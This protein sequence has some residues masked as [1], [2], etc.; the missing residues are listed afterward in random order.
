MGSIPLP[1]RYDA[2][3]YA[4]DA[5]AVLDALAERGRT[6]LVVGGTGLYFRALFDGFAATPAADP[7]LRAE[8]EAVPLPDLVERLRRADPAAPS[9]VDVQNPRRVIRAIEIVETSGRPLA[10]FRQTPRGPW[11]A[12]L[13]LGRDREELRRRI[14]QNVAAMFASGVV[15]EVRAAAGK[16]AQ[17]SP[18]PPA[19]A[20][21][22]FREITA[23]LRG[24]LDLAA[25][26]SAIVTTTQQYA[27]RQL[28]WFRRQTT[29]RP[30]DLTATSHL[31][32]AAE[33]AL[34]ALDFS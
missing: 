23:H 31:S 2:Q 21:I 10:E 26:E 15:E 14:A 18:P 28:T 29:F 20:A 25:C 27:K 11:P 13:L 6:A 24:E 8:L 4:T 1:T 7:A 9:L 17:I 16:L 34:Q 12:G 30:L 33:S 22:G 19:T 3:R 32:Q 5:R